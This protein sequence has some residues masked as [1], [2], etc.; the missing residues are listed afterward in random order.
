MTRTIVRNFVDPT[1]A[2]KRAAF[3]GDAVAFADWLRDRRGPPSPSPWRYFGAHDAFL[4][5]QYLLFPQALEYGG[6]ASQLEDTGEP[7]RE[8]LRQRASLEEG[9]LVIRGRVVGEGGGASFG[10]R[11]FVVERP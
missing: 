5:F 9:R 2:D 7:F 10:P 11:A 4:Y 1:P 8:F 6:D 3:M